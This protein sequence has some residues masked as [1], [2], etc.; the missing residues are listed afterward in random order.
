M[1]KRMSEKHIVIAL[2]ETARGGLVETG[3]KGVYYDIVF[4]FSLGS[5][6]DLLSQLVQCEK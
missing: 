4:R 6:L 2:R 1:T 3:D 5:P